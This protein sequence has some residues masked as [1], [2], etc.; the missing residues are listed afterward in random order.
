MFTNFLI[1]IREGLEAALIVSILV[2]YLVKL[3]QR[4]LLPRLWLGVIAAVVLS[5]GFAGLLTLIGAE[6][7]DGAEQIFA[8][9]MSVLAVILITWMIFWMAKRARYIKGHLQGEVDQALMRGSWAL[10]F[11][12]F[13]AVAREG[14]ETA[15]FLWAGFR[16]SGEDA[17][18]IWGAIIGLGVAVVIG[19]VI[20]RGA[21]NLDLGQLFRWTGIALIF[22][23][24]GVLAHGLGDLQ[25]A[26]VL[27]GINSLAFDLSNSIPE[28]GLLGSL[29]K[30]LLSF[31][32]QTT[33]LSFVVWWL[34]VLTTLFFFVRTTKRP[35]PQMQLA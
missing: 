4:H 34:Y 8:G 32:P 7:P 30:G 2:T 15:L 25:E 33:W 19:V 24:A 28:D 23:A 31:T 16:S 26:G 3:N 21:I 29:L 1:G 6:L 17:S 10:A 5:L 20:Y 13:L 9:T 35:A 22:V 27:P 11:I 18:A 12:A 14:L